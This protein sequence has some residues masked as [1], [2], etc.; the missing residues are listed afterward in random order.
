[1]GVFLQIK[2]GTNSHFI[3]ERETSYLVL[4]D[5]QYYEGYCIHL[6]KEHYEQ[7]T[8]LPKDIQLK[9]FQEVAHTAEVLFKSFS[10]V[11]INYACLGSECHHIHWHL[12]PRYDW[13]P[14]PTETIWTPTNH[15]RK[16]FADV[17][18]RAALVE[19][20]RNVLR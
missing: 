12:V 2:V 13:D 10:P 11:R 3:A 18:R 17:D 4:A 9:L 1:M 15:A 7:L 8:D 19:K 16:K 6:L 20:I 5:N 14:E